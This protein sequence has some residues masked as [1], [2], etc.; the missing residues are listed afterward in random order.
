MRTLNQYDRI[1]FRIPIKKIDK[2]FTVFL[3]SVLSA[4]WKVDTGED[5]TA[6]KCHG[7]CQST[8]VLRDILM[9]L[10][11]KLDTYSSKIMQ[12]VRISTTYSPR[13]MKLGLWKIMFN[14]TFYPGQTS[15]FLFKKLSVILCLKKNDT[16]Y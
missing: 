2:K 9:Y 14:A 7:R 6:M 12:P 13:A 5:I 15:E 3:D 8:D 10:K 11:K 1:Y 4:T 16:F